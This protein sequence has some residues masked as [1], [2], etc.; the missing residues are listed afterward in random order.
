MSPRGTAPLPAPDLDP[1]HDPGFA[2]AGERAA[3]A[4]ERT[5]AETLGAPIRRAGHEIRIGTASW[6]DPT[7]VKGGVFYPRGT[8]SAEDRLR[9]YASQFPVVEV[10]SSY[11]SLPEKANAT[12]WAERTPP[13]FVF[14]LKAHALLTGQPS[15]VARLPEDITDIMPAE[16]LEKTRIHAKDLPLPVYDAIWERFLDAIEPLR[17]AGKLGGVLLQYPRWFLPTPANKDLI[18]ESATRLAA[19]GATVEFRNRMWFGSEKSTGWTL[20]ML[21]DLGLTH[22]IVDGPQGL[23]SSV[24]A[25]AAVT[26]P[27]L[28]MVRLHGRR[29][30]TWE[31]A[32]VPTVERYRYLYTGAELT[33]WVERI[34]QLAEEAERTVVLYNNCYGNYGTTNARETIARL[35]VEG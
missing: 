25:V 26:T 7:I 15:E 20:D 24:P 10:D 22:V 5:P 29:A 13:G 17:R 1:A 21:R 28:A 12:L 14:H 8:S 3:R 6:T 35:S 34:E 23:E 19:V 31:A 18:A 33:P 27:K 2:D 32:K 30:A 4:L 9:Y 16:L 11:Y